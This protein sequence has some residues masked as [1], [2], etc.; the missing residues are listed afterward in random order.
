MGKLGFKNRKYDKDLLIK[1]AT[2][3]ISI[4]DLCRKMGIIRPAGGSYELIKNRCK[5]YNIDTSH[6]LGKSSFAGKRNPNYKNRLKPSEILINGHKYR[7]SHK[8]LKR[9]LL[10]CG[11]E[12]SCKEC[13]IS[14]WNGKEITLDID[15]IDGDWSNC[16]KDNLRFLCPNCHRQTKNFGSKNKKRDCNSVV[17]CQTENL[18][19]IGSTPI[20]PT[21]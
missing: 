4:S 1:Y 15:H 13:T 7:I 16:E 8:K 5:E 19:V 18:V 3:S 17:E 12:Y 10:E 9:A 21:K 2:E 11:V 6:F 20:S 14:T